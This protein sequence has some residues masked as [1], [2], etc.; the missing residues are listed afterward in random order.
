MIYKHKSTKLDGSKYWFVSLTIQLKH[1]SFVYTQ[2]N[3]WTVKFQA[4]QSNIR[5]LFAHSLIVKQFYL[6][7]V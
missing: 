7:H 2:L 3:D 5:H 6:T 4:I 1:Q